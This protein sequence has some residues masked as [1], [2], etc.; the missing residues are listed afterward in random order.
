VPG[1]KLLACLGH[2]IVNLSRLPTCPRRVLDT[3]WWWWW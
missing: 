1:S 2:Q 3:C